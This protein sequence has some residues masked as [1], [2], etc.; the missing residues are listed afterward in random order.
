MTAP[1]AQPSN[2]QI[3]TQDNAAHKCA[4][5]APVRGNMCG[6]HLDCRYDVLWGINPDTDFTRRSACHEAVTSF[7]CN[8][9]RSREGL[10]LCDGQRI[11]GKLLGSLQSTQRRVLLQHYAGQGAMVLNSM[12]TVPPPVL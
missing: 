2:V 10:S 6:H 12:C 5:F 8:S 7:R 9:M 4:R 3:L 11:S 1:K